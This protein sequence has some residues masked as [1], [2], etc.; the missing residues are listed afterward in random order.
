MKKLF[1]SLIL[2]FAFALTLIGCKPEEVEPVQSVDI[3]STEDFLALNSKVTEEYDNT[4]FKLTTDLTI[5]QYT[6]INASQTDAFIGV[7]D[8]NN[9]TVNLTVAD[10]PDSGHVGLFGCLKGATIKD[11]TINLTIHDTV[12]LNLT[13]TTIGAVAGLTIGDCTISNVTVNLSVSAVVSETVEV[14]QHTGKDTWVCSNYEYVGGVV[15]LAGGNLTIEDVSVKS[16]TVK[17]D[18]YLEDDKTSWMPVY[19]D[20]IFVGGVIGAVSTGG[21]ID[22]TATTIDTLTTTVIADTAYVGGFV[23]DGSSVCISDNST[24]I[25]TANL[26]TLTKG[27]FGG[28]AGYLKDSTIDGVT[29]D[30]DF[31]LSQLD[32]YFHFNFGGLVGYLEGT[33]NKDYNNTAIIKNSSATVNATGLTNSSDKMLGTVSYAV[34]YLKNATEKA[35]ETSGTIYFTGTELPSYWGDKYGIAYGSAKTE[36]ITTNGTS[37]GDG[38]VERHLDYSESGTIIGDPVI[39]SI[40]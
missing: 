30:V 28:V 24:A 22:I 34:G 23:G 40:A 29:V 37:I 9:K 15:G 35:I 33:L 4:N 21:K 6:P 31:D 14:N 5:D 2:I 20:T 1:L 39:P 10:I 18:S 7:L 13:T 26:K 19:C 12:K 8:G 25:A 3:A 16:M 38:S 17:A 32:S 11:L 27:Y 36:S